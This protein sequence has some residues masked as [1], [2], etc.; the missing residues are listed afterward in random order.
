[1]KKMGTSFSMCI[2]DIIR[3]VVAEEDVAFIIT[4]TAYKSREEMITQV[5]MSQQGRDIQRFMDIATRLWDRGKIYQSSNRDQKDM[6]IE[7][8]IDIPDEMFT[9]II[10]QREGQAH[11]A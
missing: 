8:W 2:R 11:V 4:S 6:F 9:N 10:P 7:R 3:G 5:A 1:M